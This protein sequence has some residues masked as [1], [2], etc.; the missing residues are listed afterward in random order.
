MK[1][2][3]EHETT[4]PNTEENT[5]QNPNPQAATACTNPDTLF[6]GELLTLAEVAKLL[7]VSRKTLYAWK[8]K[9]KIRFVKVAGVLIR[10][11]RADLTALITRDN[12]TPATTT[13]TATATA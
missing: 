11:P 5:M 8:A 6:T 1:K 13:E 10:I 12:D 4:N 9:G 7:K 2:T 3:I